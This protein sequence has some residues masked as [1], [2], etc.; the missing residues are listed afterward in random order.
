MDYEEEF[1]QLQKIEEETL[2]RLSRLRAKKDAIV[3]NYIADLRAKK[4]NSLK[5]EM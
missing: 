4:I 1:K 5:Q 3:T 2:A